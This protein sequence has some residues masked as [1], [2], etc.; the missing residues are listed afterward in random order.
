VTPASLPALLDAA[1]AVAGLEAVHLGTAGGDRLVIGDLVDVAVAEARSAGRAT[2]A[3][4]L[5][6]GG[7]AA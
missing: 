7:G 6:L 4:A 5:G 3:D 1:A 2:L